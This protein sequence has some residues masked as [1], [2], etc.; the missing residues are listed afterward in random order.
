MTG[1]GSGGLHEPQGGK[2]F[3]ED[4]RRNGESGECA[5]HLQVQEHLGI[6]ITKERC[7]LYTRQVPL[8]ARILL[9]SLR[10]PGIQIIENGFQKT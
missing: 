9:R 1:K 6:E 5:Y 2:V 8:M 10:L 4:G 7:P 3:T